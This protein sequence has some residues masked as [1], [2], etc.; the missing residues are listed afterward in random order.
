MVIQNYIILVEF[1]NMTNYI[2]CILSFIGFISAH[3]LNSY[4]LYFLTFLL[5]YLQYLITDCIN[6]IKHHKLYFLDN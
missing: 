4:I 6:Y 3:Y 5:L 2:L 1:L